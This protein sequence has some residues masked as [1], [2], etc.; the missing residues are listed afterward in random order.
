MI[1]IIL[2]IILFIFTIKETFFFNIDYISTLLGMA[3][4]AAINE[5]TT[6]TAEGFRE[7]LIFVYCSGCKSASSRITMDLFNV[8]GSNINNVEI[9][10]IDLS[11]N[12]D[13]LNLIRGFI[14][15]K[16]LKKDSFLTNTTPAPEESTDENYQYNIKRRLKDYFH[17]H[18]SIRSSSTT[19]NGPDFYTHEQ[20][21]HTS[22]KSVSGISE[23]EQ[24]SEYS[25]NECDYFLVYK[26]PTILYEIKDHAYLKFPEEFPLQHYPCNL[27]DKQEYIR[28]IDEFLKK[29]KYWI[30]YLKHFSNK[31]VGLYNLIR[32]DLGTSCRDESV[33][34]ITDTVTVKDAHYNIIGKY[35]DILCNSYPRTTDEFNRLEKYDEKNT[36][37]YKEKDKSSSTAFL[38]AGDEN[39]LDF[40]KVNRTRVP[41]L[42]GKLTDTDPE[43]V[44]IRGYK[45]R[46]VQYA[47]R[48]LMIYFENYLRPS[49]VSIPFVDNYDTNP[50]TFMLNIKNFVL[51]ANCTN[52]QTALQQL[53][54]I[55]SDDPDIG[56]GFP[57][58][59]QTWRSFV[60]PSTGKANENYGWYLLTFDKP[61]V[62]PPNSPGNIWKVCLS[63]SSGYNLCFQNYPV[64]QFNIEFGRKS[65]NMEIRRFQNIIQ[66]CLL[67]YGYIKS[68]REDKRLFGCEHSDGDVSSEIGS[69]TSNDLQNPASCSQ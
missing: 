33:E 58:P 25:S 44:T 42:V 8:I 59:T 9:T 28:K 54:N 36:D 29:I 26:T 15:P 6:A 52:N 32:I 64:N 1:L 17:S 60:D 47:Q 3:E 14:H 46:L 11:R 7:K 57:S 51:T 31:L 4:R 48:T 34:L 16:Y 12:N 30:Y 67:E 27:E 2:F 24:S 37:F 56:S 5:A 69:A 38:T 62:L 55:F 21:T 35:Y 53:K 40:L 23:Y 20:P 63:N 68:N 45:Q 10:R 43:G 18:N 22:I 65:D 39:V 41:A 61:L 19:C 13:P 50:E 49:G 66:P